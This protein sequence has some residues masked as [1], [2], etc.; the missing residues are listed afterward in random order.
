MYWKS[1][2][3]DAVTWSFQATYLSQQSPNPQWFNSLVWKP[4]ISISW[5]KLKS[6][7]C[8]GQT[9]K[10]GVLERNRTLPHVSSILCCDNCHLRPPEKK[11][12]RRKTEIPN[13]SSKALRRWGRWR[14]C[15]FM[16]T[17]AN[18]LHWNHWPPFAELFLPWMTWS[19]SSP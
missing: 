15:V 7:A 4:I 8:R 16:R 1:S 2:S 18:L 3:R 11:K 10:V 5:T 14:G 6:L 19:C 9:I 12:R 17:C 13:A